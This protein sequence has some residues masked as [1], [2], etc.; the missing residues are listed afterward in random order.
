MRIAIHRDQHIPAFCFLLSAGVRYPQPLLEEVIQTLTAA[1]Q[2]PP[3]LGG[4][5]ATLLDS[6]GAAG[7]VT[8]PK[9][10]LV[11]AAKLTLGVGLRAQ[12]PTPVSKQ[13]LA[14][15]LRCGA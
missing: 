8:I 5:Q 7:G 9:P 3:A 13:A 4:T 10:Q 11:I 1:M 15:A 14:K 12:S 6:Y 2:L